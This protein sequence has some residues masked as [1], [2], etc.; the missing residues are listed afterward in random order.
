MLSLFL[1]G[2][3]SCYL[4]HTI[5]RSSF[6]IYSNRAKKELTPDDYNLLRKINISIKEEILGFGEFDVLAI[7]FYKKVMDALK[8]P[9][10]LLNECSDIR[11]KVRNMKFLDPDVS[12]GNADEPQNS[13]ICMTIYITELTT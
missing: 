13:R 10:E 8:S 12:V 11:E 3:Y 9:E 5:R 6:K 2:G 4:E 7:S 1:Q